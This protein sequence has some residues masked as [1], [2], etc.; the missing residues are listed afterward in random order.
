MCKADCQ[1]PPGGSTKSWSW[2]QEKRQSRE[3]TLTTSHVENVTG[4]VS[5]GR[6]GNGSY[7]KS[8]C[9]IVSELKYIFVKSHYQV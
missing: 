4:I 9:N 8:G 7:I 3:E 6:W 5:S 2:V 1:W